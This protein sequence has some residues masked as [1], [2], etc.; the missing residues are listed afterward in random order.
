MFWWILRGLVSVLL[1]LVVFAC[2]LVL[3]VFAGVRSLLDDET[4]VKPLA[5]VNAYQRIYTEVLMPEAI[6]ELRNDLF[7]GT[8]FLSSQEIADLMYQLAPPDYLRSQVES[9]SALLDD[10]L[11]GE[12]NTLKL[13]L[14]LGAPLD[15]LTPAVETLI[16]NKIDEATELVA[17][18][19]VPRVDELTTS[20]DEQHAD[21]I[22]QTLESLL[23][24]ESIS[25]SVSD[26]TGYSE[27]ELL[28]IFD[29]SV[30][31]IL[32]NPA[33]D[34]RSRD[35][36]EET[37]PELRQTFV[38]GNVNYFLKE[39]TRV[40]VVPALDLAIGDLKEQLDEQGRVDLVSLLAEEV[41]EIEESQL[42]DTAREWRDRMLTAL[43]WALLVPLLTLILAIATM[44]LV[45]WRRPL[46]FYRWTYLTL[47]IAGG[48]ALAALLTAY[49][50]LPGAT[51]GLIYVQLDGLESGLPG[52]LPLASE[53]A[54]AM[55]ASLLGG[56]IWIAA[57]PPLASAVL[58][59]VSPVYNRWLKAKEP[60]EVE[61]EKIEP[62][63]SEP[64]DPE[65]PVENCS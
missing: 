58:W 39:A 26:L 25:T 18:E 53:L 9:N 47:L 5:E 36:I 24:G 8:E 31:V 64:S 17:A 48:A 41:M 44:F 6:D 52:L 13:Y 35:L 33:V 55:V 7:G 11:S 49:F 22:S 29:Q 10:Y 23:T 15:R 30:E 51:E 19:V 12:S 14:D 28:E 40:T 63:D 27:A 45:Y 62:E 1:S 46:A 42:Q 38:T 20:L 54:N 32:A 59:L 4:Y 56:L 43:F 16:E 3:L 34:D 21:R 61:Q 65:L 50:T 37:V 57:I 2:L 60:E